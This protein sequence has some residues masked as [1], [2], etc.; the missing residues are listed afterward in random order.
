M[1]DLIGKPVRIV[2]RRLED[3]WPTFTVL[4]YDPPMLHLQGRDDG[5]WKHYGDTFW[6][7]VSE[8]ASIVP[9]Q[10]AREMARMLVDDIRK[11]TGE[12]HVS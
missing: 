5:R 10:M 4:A 2:W 8:F 1:R 11:L 7:N 12:D 9:E 6:V 3:D